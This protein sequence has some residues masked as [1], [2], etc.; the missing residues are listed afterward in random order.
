MCTQAQTNGCD[1]GTDKCWNGETCE[2]NRKSSTE[3]EVQI[4]ELIPYGD[5]GLIINESEEVETG[6]DN[7]DA[8]KQRNK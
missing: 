2:Y 4:E 7:S 3:G 5:D 8:T 1:C 6:S